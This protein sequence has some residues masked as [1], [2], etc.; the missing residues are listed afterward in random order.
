MSP[1]TLHLFVWLVIPDSTAMTTR[2]VL[3]RLDFASLAA[4]HRCARWRMTFEG[5]PADWQELAD[6]LRRV[7]VLVNA[8]KH[9]AAVHLDSDPAVPP[10]PPLV[11]RPREGTHAVWL[12]VTSP[13]DP[14]AEH[15]GAILR[16]R[17][18]FDRLSACAVDDLWRLDICLE[19]RQACRAVAERAARTLLVNPEFQQ[20]EVI[21]A[22]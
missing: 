6:R 5:P 7:D 18:G 16:D 12:A 22:P 1:F 15:V 2:Q 19:T 21:D 4:V 20:L 14:R 8:N 10:L 11:P 13:F 3:H 17:L 9:R